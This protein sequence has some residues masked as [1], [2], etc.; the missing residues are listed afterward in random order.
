MTRSAL[1]LGVLAIIS[2][3]LASRAALI[4]GVLTISGTAELTDLGID[5]LNSNLFTINSPASSQQGGFTAFAGTNGTI[6]NLS[7]V[8]GAV[9][10]LNFMTF[11]AAPNITIT[12]TSI[13]AGFDS[14]AGCAATPPAPGQTC[15]PT[16]TSLD[17][18]NTSAT[19]S[20]LSFG[21]AGV[22]KDS[23]TGETTPITG[24]FTLPFVSDSFQTVLATIA[25]EGTA[26]TAFS[27]Q[28]TTTTPS[29]PA[30]P[31]PSSL[32]SLIAGLGMI[33]GTVARRKKLAKS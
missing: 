6:Q 14:A 16:G 17:F 22:E 18:Q 11:A 20:S 27:A 25:G 32:I 30:V 8:A 31:E 19:S 12:L 23:L 7:D 1:A 5:F 24:L 29:T 15:T 26:T 3:P 33:V 13:N 4:D 10:T 9:D 21:I 2:M 28:F